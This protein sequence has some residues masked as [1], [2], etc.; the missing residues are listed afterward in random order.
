MSAA[1]Y[2]RG[3]GSVRIPSYQ[4][5]RRVKLA[6]FRDDETAMELHVP[7]ADHINNNQNVLHLWR[8]HA[9]EIPRPPRYMV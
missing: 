5:M 6:F 9:V 7:P 1:V 2:R 4:E 3:R 8:P